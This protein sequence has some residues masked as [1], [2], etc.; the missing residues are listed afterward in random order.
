MMKKL[1][2]AALLLL[3]TSQAK[4]QDCKAYIPGEVGT[5]TEQTHYDKKDKVTGIS[6]MEVT[7]VKSEGETTYFKVKQTHKDKKGENPSET[8]MGFRCENG[9]FYIDM[10]MFVNEEQMQ[11]YE[12]MEMKVTMEALDMPSKLTP[13]QKLNDGSI[14]LEVVNGSPIPIKFTIEVNNRQVGQRENITTPAGS[15]DCVVLT[16][17]ITTKT[18]FSFTVQSKEWYAEGIGVVKSETYRKEKLM[19]YSLLTKLQK[20]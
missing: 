9:T 8:E 12:D 17:D 19:G 7:E 13:G 2:Y 5:I 1:F 4:S 10:N 6:T 16:Q 15:F 14:T 20:P 18:G 11:A 3:I